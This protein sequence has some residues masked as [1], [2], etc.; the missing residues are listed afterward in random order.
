M[1]YIWKQ[2]FLTLVFK[3]VLISYLSVIVQILITMREFA[4]FQDNRKLSLL[5]LLD[6]SQ[7]NYHHIVVTKRKAKS[8]LISATRRYGPW[9]NQL[10]TKER[11]LLKPTALDSFLWSNV[12]FLQGLLRPL[13]KGKAEQLEWRTKQSAA[14]W[15]GRKEW[16]LQNSW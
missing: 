5:K 13:L 2:R 10:Y 1:T 8:N 6:K 16:A 4:S 14:P 15:E 3:I 9:Q 11:K 7:I 12:T